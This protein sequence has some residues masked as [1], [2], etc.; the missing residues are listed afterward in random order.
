MKNLK[1]IWSLIGQEQKEIENNYYV[2]LVQIG[3]HG[4]SRLVMS[5]EDVNKKFKSGSLMDLFMPER[6]DIRVRSAIK[7][8]KEELIED[9]ALKV[10]NSYGWFVIEHSQGDKMFTARLKRWEGNEVGLE[11]TD[12]E[13]D[14]KYT[15]EFDPEMI[16]SWKDIID[17]FD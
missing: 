14:K 15:K 8:M 10:S 17:L 9:T 1:E 7:V 11:L 2:T 13:Y 16:K 5:E 4:R 6:S 3:V 12:E